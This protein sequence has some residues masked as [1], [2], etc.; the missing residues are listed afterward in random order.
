MA[1]PIIGYDYYM[2]LHMGLCRG[3]VDELVE[4]KVGDRSVWPIAY[5][6]QTGGGSTLSFNGFFE[7]IV[8][9]SPPTYSTVAPPPP[10]TASVNQVDINA[11]NVFGGE[12]AEGGIVGKLD[13]MMG[14]ATQA[15]N[16]RV[17][18]LVGGSLVSAF[19]GVVTAFFR[20][21]VAHLN[22]Y[23]K[24]W[25]FRLRRAVKGW[26]DDVC[27][28][29]SLAIIPINRPLS[30]T[31]ED[32]RQDVVTAAH[33]KTVFMEGTVIPE[34]GVGPPFTANVT[35]EGTSPVL[36][37]LKVRG[38]NKFSSAPM[39]LVLREGIHYTYAAGVIT[40]IGSFAEAGVATVNYVDNLAVEVVFTTTV[41]ITTP[42]SGVDAGGVV[43]V[44]A[45]N[46]AH[47]IY[48]C[49]TNRD[50]GRGFGSSRLDVASF[51]YASEVLFSEGLG[52]CLKWANETTIDDFVKKVVDHVG[53]AVFT[54]RKTG[55]LTLK[56]LRD[57]YTLASL[58]VFT[59]TTGILSVS[60]DSSSMTNRSAN[61]IVVKYIDAFTGNDASLRLQNLAAI[62][63][64]NGIVSKTV[65]YPGLPTS[66]LAARV[67][68]RDLRVHSYPL[69]RFTFRMDR[70]AWELEPMS[71]FRYQDPSRGVADMVMRVFNVKDTAGSVIEIVA[72][73]DVFGLSTAAYVAPTVN[74]Q[75]SVSP[76]P[77]PAT[78]TAVKEASYYDLLTLLTAAER[79]ALTG[80]ET[81]V[82]LVS[83]KPTLLSSSYDVYTGSTA[84]GYSVKG[85]G[86][87]TPLGQ[88][89]GAIDSLVSSGNIQAISSLGSVVPGD[90]VS[91]D[92]EV[93]QL[94][95]FNP[96]TGAATFSRG[97]LDTLPASH[98]DDAL[99]WVFSKGVGIDTT[100]YAENQ[101]QYG[102]ALTRTAAG[103]LPVASAPEASL[104]TVGRWSRPY[105]PGAVKINSIDYRSPPGTLY[106][107]FTVSWAHRNKELQADV[108]RNQ[109]SL[110]V[111]PPAGLTYTVRMYRRSDNA[112]VANITG[113]TGTLWQFSEAIWISM[114]KV[115][116]VN[117]ELRSVI[118]GVE[119]WQGYL[120]PIDITDDGFG[121]NFGNQFSSI[122]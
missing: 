24:T 22:P 97:C 64:S 104:T 38:Q 99:V 60:D 75:P 34:F 28:N 112:L 17:S 121:M 79:S 20:G 32:E 53:G 65:D 29:P 47:I 82:Y 5:Q 70:R 2:D 74:E 90:L 12:K 68:M 85:Q 122:A 109:L 81:F 111:T 71:V 63:S 98:A 40:F 14:E 41:T 43:L 116:E 6:Q 113:I 4:I 86:V 9:T 59:P 87:W 55:L 13:V 44:K 77:T 48:E 108:I 16:P 114:G 42:I 69:R 102:R 80:D 95:T 18:A 54:S 45:M 50:W 30:S 37:Y 119:S 62:Q 88:L 78:Y 94:V 36:Q 58:P 15:V 101:T 23:P 21:L 10:I 3:P 57:D 76:N 83:A 84:A 7:P 8:T 73:Q 91:I 35:L 110:S 49:A 107:N 118:A 120:I 72:V 26:D 56:L 92:N 51:Q 103:V 67:G 25:K 46:P 61:E 117:L 105:P 52:L 89:N 100:R 106:P 19:R 1:D 31:E 66:D 96:S 11:P 33:R 115:A 93:L 39:S 27:W